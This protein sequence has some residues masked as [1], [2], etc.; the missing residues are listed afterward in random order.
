VRPRQRRSDAR[1][2]LALISPALVVVLA[3]VVVPMA[4]TFLMAFQR[5]RLADLRHSSIFGDY[6]LANL[7]LVLTSKDT[8]ESLLTT[9]AFAVGA[10]SFSIALGL[11][12]ALVVRRPFR[13]RA[14]VRAAML[15]P[16][17]MPV[18]AAAFVWTVLLNP[19]FGLVNDW[20]TRLF[21]WDKAVAFLSQPRGEISLLGLDIAIPTALLTV[22][23]FEV[24][25]QFPFAFLFLLARLQAVP[26]EIEEAGRIDGA[27][28][29]QSF[30]HILLPQLMPV[31][32]VLAVL[33]LVWS[34]TEFNDI[35]LLTKATADTEVWSTRVYD[36]LNSQHNVGA[37]AAQ[38]LVLAAIPLV[39]V[40]P[41]LRTHKRAR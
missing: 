24:W 15:L 19:Q 23:A 41:W 3:V 29:L 8:W 10:T 9:L 38:T 39:F 16:Y 27:T 31:I 35:Y 32:A 13:G 5:L 12:A 7:R 22:I 2:G 17:I 28:P 40:W 14:I 20:G 37:A 26:S 11:V 21:G 18:V 6:T 30:R 1:L 36:L 4:W 33:R 25:R 34:F